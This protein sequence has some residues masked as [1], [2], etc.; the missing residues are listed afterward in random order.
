MERKSV[1]MV[2]FHYNLVSQPDGSAQK[3]IKTLLF[4]LKGWERY[5]FGVKREGRMEKRVEEG[6]H[7]FGV[8]EDRFK[9]WL[10]NKLFRAGKFTYSRIVKLLNRYQPQIL[11]LHNRCELAD[12]LY[13]RLNYRPILLCHYHRLFKEPVFPK[14]AARFIGVSQFLAEVL[15]GQIDRDRQNLVLSIP[16]P[17]PYDLLQFPRVNFR[18][19]EGK[20]QFLFPFGDDQLKGFDIIPPLLKYLE[21]RKVGYRFHLTGKVKGRLPEFFFTSPNISVY[22]HLSREEFYQ[23]LTEVDFLLLPSRREAFSLVILEALYFGVRPIVS[24]V[25]GI[26][27]VVGA[28]YP[29]FISPHPS[30]GEILER[31]QR[32]AQLPPVQWREL[33]DLILLRFNPQKIAGQLEELYLSLLSGV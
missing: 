9:N 19:V 22:G 17:L 32:G 4:N 31:F 21:E 16:N 30:P 26:P 25:G 18:P 20:F 2:D 6:V 15:K 13:S 7:F 8:P 33:A 14:S 5:G 3:V 1:G 28:E 23:L 10:F 24:E 27:E 29:F 12:P 11:H